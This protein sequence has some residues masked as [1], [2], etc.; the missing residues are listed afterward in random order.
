[1]A[2][3]YGFGKFVVESLSEL[4]ALDV[5]SS[6]NCNTVPVVEAC[7]SAYPSAA[8]ISS[9]AVGVENASGRLEIAPKSR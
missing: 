7:M 5:A 9:L 2:A 4:R 3:A 6:S 8:P 1:V